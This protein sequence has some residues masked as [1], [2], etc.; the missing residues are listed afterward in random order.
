[1]RPRSR[2][3]CPPAETGRL[4]PSGAGA[5][6]D[7]P[8]LSK[9]LVWRLS[10]HDAAADSGKGGE[11]DSRPDERRRIEPPDHTI[12]IHDIKYFQS[13]LLDN[14]SDEKVPSPVNFRRMPPGVG[15]RTLAAV[16]LHANEQLPPAL[17]KVLA[18]TPGFLILHISAD[19][20]LEKEN[21]RQI[22]AFIDRCREALAENFVVLTS[23]NF[24]AAVGLPLVDNSSWE[25]VA[26]SL[27]R[28]WD[29]DD[30]PGRGD[31]PAPAWSSTRCGAAAT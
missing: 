20:K 31:D 16:Y 4:P 5:A 23:S 9:R 14:S 13:K 15:P 28:V 17:D 22:A 3:A 11:E 30:D 6:S 18:G 12:R 21:A 8:G 1:M 2:R 29:A 19:R 10:V 27:M 26:D 25:A 7:P 24:F